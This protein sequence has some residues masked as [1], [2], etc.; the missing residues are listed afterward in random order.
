MRLNVA[1]FFTEYE[2]LQR[3][4][5]VTIYDAAGNQFQETLAVNDGDTEAYGVE[6]ELTYVP[7]ENFRVDFNLGTL[8]H[9]Y[10]SFTPTEATSQQWAGVDLSGMTVPF[11]PELNYGL[12][13]TYSIDLQSGGMVTL[14]GSVHHQGEMETQ[15]YPADAQAPGVLR[16]KQYTQVE[17]RTLVGAYVRWDSPQNSWSVTAYGKNLTDERWRQSANAV[18]GLWNFTRFAPPREIGVRVGFSF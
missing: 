12:A 16:T 15:P 2:S 14:N 6:V 17:E 5:V 7:T 13:A 4:Q 11:S 18:A 8:K 1:G 9:N 10:T 3:S